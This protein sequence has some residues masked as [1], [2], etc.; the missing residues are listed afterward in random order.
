MHSFNQC[1][2]LVDVILHRAFNSKYDLYS[3]VLEYLYEVM[4]KMD[5]E[6]YSV[7]GLYSYYENHYNILSSDDFVYTKIL[8]EENIIRF[9]YKKKTA[10]E[11]FVK[12]VDSA[13]SQGKFMEMK[14]IY[15]QREIIKVAK[16]SLNFYYKTASQNVFASLFRPNFIL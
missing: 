4:D 16:L 12:F 1:K 2:L 5:K 15:T 13:I 6:N 8:N 7:L 9:D 11:R 10:I 14:V 3:H